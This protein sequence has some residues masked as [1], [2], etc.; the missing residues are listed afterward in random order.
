MT[1][2]L[3]DEQQQEM[4]QRKVYVAA[5]WWRDCDAFASVAANSAKVC[6]RKIMQAMRDAA[7]DAYNQSEP[8]D[9]KTVDDYLEDLCWSGV[10]L[11]SLED[12]VP[13]WEL[14]RYFAHVAADIDACDMDSLLSGDADAYVWLPVA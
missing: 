1:K 9:E 13:H 4:R 2:L 5:C 10:S 8:E 3:K 12:V 7:V 11:E 14:D 6:E